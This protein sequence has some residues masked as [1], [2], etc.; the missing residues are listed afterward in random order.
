M[1]EN[2]EYSPITLVTL[3]EYHFTADFSVNIQNCQHTF[4]QGNDI[5]V[6]G[7]KLC[8]KRHCCKVDRLVII[9]KSD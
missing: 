7:I 2:G 6:N 9:M 3:S 8:L 5:E 4:D 1:Q